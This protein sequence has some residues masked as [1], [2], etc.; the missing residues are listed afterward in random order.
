MKPLSRTVTRTVSL[1]SDVMTTL[2]GAPVRRTA[3]GSSF[4]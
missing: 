1:I 2:P 4:S 3:T